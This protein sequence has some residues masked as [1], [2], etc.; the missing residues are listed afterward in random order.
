MADLAKSGVIDIDE[1]SLSKVIFGGP[2]MGVAVPEH[3]NS[4]AKEHFRR[5]SNEC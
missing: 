3:R 2:M 1:E 5:S 4:S